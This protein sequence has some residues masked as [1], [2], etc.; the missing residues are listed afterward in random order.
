MHLKESGKL[1]S[2]EKKWWEDMNNDGSNC[3]EQHTGPKTTESLDIRHLG[4]VFIILGMGLGF[5]F[6]VACVERLMK[7]QQN[8][9]Q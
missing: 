7:S 9:Q 2:I 5:S 3:L 8:N 4:G 1:Q 6:L